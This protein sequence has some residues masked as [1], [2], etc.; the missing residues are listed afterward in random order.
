M[1]VLATNSLSMPSTKFGRCFEATSSDSSSGGKMPCK[2]RRVISKG[3]RG[4][5]GFCAAKGR[6]EQDPNGPAFMDDFAHSSPPYR[7]DSRYHIHCIRK[8]LQ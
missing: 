2:H 5:G 3:G 1:Q 6:F 8:M 7:I 4:G